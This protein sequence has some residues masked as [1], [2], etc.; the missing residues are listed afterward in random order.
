MIDAIMRLKIHWFFVLLVAGCA[1]AQMHQPEPNPTVSLEKIPIRRVALIDLEDATQRADKGMR[2][3]IQ[4][5]LEQGLKERITVV[6][7]LPRTQAM[8]AGWLRQQRQQNEV[9]GFITGKITG[10]RFQGTKRRV[11][12]S[13]T[14]RL[15]GS[16]GQIL[17]SRSSVGLTDVLP[18][19][20]LERLYYVAAQR[21]TKEFTDDLTAQQ[22]DGS[23]GARR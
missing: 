18:D 8:G 4:S 1:A 17:W 19:Q 21:A 9:Q 13:L 23:G 5:Q 6:G 16:E 20:P 10:C 12:V 14:M 7:P 11:W 15:L 3:A 2:Q 22:L